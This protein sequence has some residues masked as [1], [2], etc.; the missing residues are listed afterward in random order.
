MVLPDINDLEQDISM[1]LRTL[2]MSKQAN[3]AVVSTDAVRLTGIWYALEAENALL[4]KR[5]ITL[6]SSEL[7]CSKIDC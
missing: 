2:G 7:I 4:R 5:T 6:F 1:T 3:V